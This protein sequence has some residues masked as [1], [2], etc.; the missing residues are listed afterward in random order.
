MLSNS[1]RKLEAKIYN[2]LQSQVANLE[3]LLF[4][5]VKIVVFVD[6]VCAAKFL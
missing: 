1:H 3:C 2:T 5:L 6:L 4:V